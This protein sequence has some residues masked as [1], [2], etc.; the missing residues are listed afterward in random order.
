MFASHTLVVQ[1]QLKRLLTAG[2]MEEMRNVIYRDGVPEPTDS[3]MVETFKNLTESFA[4]YTAGSRRIRAQHQQQIGDVKL[5]YEF[6][7]FLNSL[8]VDNNVI[9]LY[10]RLLCQICEQPPTA[11]YIT[12]CMHIYCEGCLP[13]SENAAT[14]ICAGCKSEILE[15]EYC[16]SIED[17][18]LNE[19]LSS[20]FL[21]QGRQRSRK[22]VS[23]ANP[24][25]EEQY[26]ADWIQLA[27]HKM[28]GAKLAATRDCISDWFSQ[29]SDTKILIFTQFLD[30]GRIL[31]LM[32]ENEKWGFAT[33]RL[34]NHAKIL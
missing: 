22:K 17:L 5:T 9:E 21:S 27:G 3:K 34:A 25:R 33:V 29:S 12:P 14:A 11:A 24:N 2:T 8:K 23:K 16:N 26:G 6:C 7:R 4:A 28:H 19:Q 30:M 15:T 1:Q 18:G 31:G 32:C 20:A 13:I 10:R